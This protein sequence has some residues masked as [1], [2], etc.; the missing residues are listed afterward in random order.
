M[1][2]RLQSIFRGLFR[3][4]PPLLVLLFVWVVGAIFTKFMWDGYR[5]IAGA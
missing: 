4:L 3:E 1:H 5:R 2:G